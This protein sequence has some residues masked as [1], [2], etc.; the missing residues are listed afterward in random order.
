MKQKIILVSFIFLSF[1]KMEG[2]NYTNPILSGFYPDPSICTDGKNY[3]L[4]NSTFA[5]FPGIPIFKSKDLV[6]WKLLGYAMNRNEQ[7]DLTNTGVS[8]GLF[9][10]T[11][12]YNNGIFYILCTLVDKGGNF[13]ITSKNPTGPWSNPIWL[14]NITGIDPSIDFIDDKVFITYNSEAPYNKP[15]YNGHRTIRQ[16]E[17]DIAK[18]QTIGEEKILVNGGTDLAKNP[19]WIEGPHF[20]K[21]DNWYYLICAEGGTGYNHSEVVFRKKKLN[22]TL[23]SYEKNPILTQ[24]HLDTTRKNPITTTGHADFVKAPNGD[25][26]SVFLGCRPYE[27]DYYNTGR[28]TFMLPVKW[29]N[30]WPIILQSNET[31]SLNNKINVTNKTKSNFSE[32]IIFNDNFNNNS[33][34]N[35]YAFLRNPKDG[36]Y[37]IKNGKLILQVNAANCSQKKSLYFIGFRQSNINCEA[38]TTLKFNPNNDNEYAGLLVFQ[39]EQHY[40]YLSKKNVNNKLVI[41]VRKSVV[42]FNKNDESTQEE[43]LVSKN[44]ETNEPMFLKIEAIGSVYNFYYAIKKND[45]Q[46]LAK[47]V[48]GKFL[49]TKIAGGFVG[50]F[51]A[52]YATSNGAPTT[53]NATFNWFNY[54]GKD[55]IYDK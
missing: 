34:N 35:R 4:V 42:A 20:F 41:Q 38:S 47:N 6:N 30:D 45:W 15:L 39:N 22:D 24:R 14:K 54:L 13:I 40:Y 27:G 12:R 17:F 5:Y 7:L 50:S 48:D 25:W 11:I 51:F 49:S 1:I 3:Y 18:M 8:R 46:I 9:A 52:M 28:E 2:Q 10:P 55:K 29:E 43:I 36:F 32:N 21:K 53:N 33:L 19:I 23:I 44:L 31:V 26:Y 37:K 16:Y